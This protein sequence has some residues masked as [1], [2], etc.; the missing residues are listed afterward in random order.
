MN[1]FN[2]FWEKRMQWSSQNTKTSKII[3]FFTGANNEKKQ[4]NEWV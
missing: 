3:G 4:I 2:D 1:N